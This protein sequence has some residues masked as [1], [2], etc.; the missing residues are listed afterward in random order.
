VNNWSLTP[1]VTNPLLSSPLVRQAISY[2]VD[3]NEVAQKAE[4][5]FTLPA[6]QTGNILPFKAWYNRAAD[7]RYGY[8]KHNPKKALALLT[9]AGFKRGSDGIFRAKN[10]DKLSVTIIH[11][12]AFSDSVAAATIMAK[13]LKEVGIDAKPESLAGNVYASRVSNGDFTLAWAQVSGSVAPFYEYRN[14]LHSA[15]TAPNGKAA[16]S[17]YERWRSPATDRLLDAYGRTRDQKTQRKIINQIQDIMVT[18]A[19]VIPVLQGVVWNEWSDKT[20]VGW[21]TQSNPYIN[22]CGYCTADMG[23]GVVL[24]RLHL[25]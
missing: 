12:G 3:R 15:N 20:F 16:L 5:G 7:A 19:P 1:N 4:F 18:Q 21:S 25:R 14:L 23:I 10:G 6:S 8:F 17:N 24:N 9:K 22:P 13:Q 11:I 2:A